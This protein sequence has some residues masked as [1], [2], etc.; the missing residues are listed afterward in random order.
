LFAIVIISGKYTKKVIFGSV[1]FLITVAPVLQFVPIGIPTGLGVV[2]DHFIYVSSVGLF[3]LVSEGFVWL[4][5]SKLKA[6]SLLKNLAIV[7]LI[8]VLGTLS[9]LSWKRCHVWVSNV[10]LWSDI[11]EELP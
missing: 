1:F 8:L 4:Y 10:V 3:Y 7:I 9:T 5:Y 2:A 6:F 11:F